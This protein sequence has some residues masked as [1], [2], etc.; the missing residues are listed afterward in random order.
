MNRVT[1]HSV[2]SM[3]ALFSDDQPIFGVNKARDHTSQSGGS[4][5]LLRFFVWEE[6]L[7]RELVGRLDVRS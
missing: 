5:S 1:P 3:R 6:D 2:Q 4:C 7:P